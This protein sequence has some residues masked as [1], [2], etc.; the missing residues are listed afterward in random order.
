[1]WRLQLHSWFYVIFKV[2]IHHFGYLAKLIFLN[3]SE[4]CFHHVANSHLIS[5]VNEE[6]ETY[7]TKLNLNDDEEVQE[8]I[9]RVP[10]LDPLQDTLFEPFPLEDLILD[11]VSIKRSQL[12]IAKNLR[13]RMLAQ[14]IKKAFTI[15][16]AQP[17]KWPGEESEIADRLM[18]CRRI[19]SCNHG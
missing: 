9:Y 7:F 18:S 1:V 17:D 19:Y 16:G 12:S 5:G 6:E 10:A 8:R 4:A 13:A 14:S 3:E 11:D 2:N 15:I